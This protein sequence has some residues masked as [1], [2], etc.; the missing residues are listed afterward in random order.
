MQTISVEER[1]KLTR[2]TVR[3]II[4]KHQSSQKREWYTDHLLSPYCRNSILNLACLG[5]PMLKDERAEGTMLIKSG[6]RQ[7]LRRKE[8]GGTPYVISRWVPVIRDIMEVSLLSGSHY[9]ILSFSH[10]VC[11]RGPPGP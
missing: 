3:V 7:Q 10:T 4:E 2:S 9:P 1:I 11:H 8:R 6:P 5:Y